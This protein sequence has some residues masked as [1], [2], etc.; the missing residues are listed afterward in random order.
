LRSV[1]TALAIGLLLLAP[2]AARAGDAE[3]AAWASLV[4][5]AGSAEPAARAAAIA[6]VR[7]AAN[8]RALAAVIAAATAARRDRDQATVLL[9]RTEVDLDAVWASRDTEDRAFERLRTP[10][11]DRVEKHNRR[12]Q[13]MR[14]Q[15]DELDAAADAASLNL[16]R[17]EEELDGVRRAAAS[18]LARVSENDVVAA[19]ARLAAAWLRAT[20]STTEDRVR[21]VESIEHVKSPAVAATLREIA[22]DV[23]GDPRV[24][25]TALDARA[26]RRDDG[27]LTDA[28]AAL[29]D[30]SWIVRAT[31]IDV[32]RTMH[33]R[34]AI[35]PLIAFLGS[36]DPGR[37]RED[38][39]RALRSLTGE[40]HGPYREP[41]ATWWAESKRDFEL[42]RRPQSLAALAAPEQGLTFYGITTFSDRVLFVLD[43][44]GSMAETDRSAPR[45]SPTRKVDAAR[46]ELVSALD[47]LS[48][49]AHFGV[50]L[51]DRAVRRFAGGLSR[52]DAPSRLRARSWLFE[53]EPRGETNLGDA[54]REAFR[55]AAGLD[56]PSAPLG[57]A[58]TV[59]L[60]T[61]GRPTAGGLQSSDRILDAVRRWNRSAR[62]TIHCVGLGDHDSGLLTELAAMTGGRYVK[63]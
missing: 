36:D 62:I 13:E 54:L 17:R 6:Q 12:D 51:F 44:S 63:R 33:E 48:D 23:R 8:P 55:L 3:E 7:V 29:L 25:A 58:D 34:E 11:F 14:R 31:A 45:S 52:A 50:L 2:S 56:G 20:D 39:C 28:I 10:D 1:R 49:R 46:R 30:P 32:L 37:L 42:P 9:R 27:T 4:R 16:A 59:F 18:I 57:G 26:A 19:I 40:K 60:L 15:I 38:A 53:R 21:F 22:F 47:M 5:D 61:D 43:T 35:E 41:W 24:R